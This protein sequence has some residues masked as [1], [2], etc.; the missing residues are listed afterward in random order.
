[1][2]KQLPQLRDGETMTGVNA[3][4]RRTLL[5]KRLDL[6]DKLLRQIFQLRAEAR[7]HALSGPDQ[8]FAERGQFC[9]FSALG[10]DQRHAEKFGPLLDQIPDV[11][12]GEMGVIGGT[13]EFPGFTDLVEDSEHDN[14]GLRTAFLVESPHGFNFD[15]QHR[16]AK[17]MK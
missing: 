13:G 10:L 12:I 15:M 6:S 9:P 16:S 14:R 8:L 4:D 11:P 5:Q 17:V 7:L 1:M 2:V 3:D